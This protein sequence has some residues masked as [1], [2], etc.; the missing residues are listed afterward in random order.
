MRQLKLLVR[1]ARIGL[2]GIAALSLALYAASFAKIYWKP[3]SSTIASVS[4]GRIE[5]HRWGQKVRV[6][7]VPEGWTLG[8]P[9]GMSFS[10]LGGGPIAVRDRPYW[11][12]MYSTS[13]GGP[14]MYADD[15]MI[16]PLKLALLAGPAGLLLLGVPTRRKQQGACPACGY[17]RAGLTADTAC[18]EC[19]AGPAGVR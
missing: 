18:P 6:K 12:G 19:G 7:G 4:H 3:G 16:Y 9:K 1:V 15:L 10:F 11:L 17:D 14:G 8:D 2:L 13:R 5:V